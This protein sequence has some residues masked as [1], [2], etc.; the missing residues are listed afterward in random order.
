MGDLILSDNAR[1]PTLVDSPPI[2]QIKDLRTEFV[3]EQGVVKAVNGVSFEVAAGETLGIVG[4]SGSG[5]TVTMLSVMRLIDSPPGRIKDGQ[6][7]FKGRDLLALGRRE[8]RQVRG[9][10]IAM[11]FQDPL[12][13]L[14]PV[15]SIGDQL[16]EP[17]RLHLGMS[18][19]DAVERVKESLAQVGIPDPE[20]AL[21]A[22]P[23]QFSGGMRQRVM[24]AM[25]ISCNPTLLIADEPTTA[26]DVTVQEQLLALVN[27]L[28]SKLGMSVVWITHD[29]GVIAGLADRVL[30]M[31]AGE[32]VEQG[33][34]VTIFENPRHPYTQ[35]LLRSIPRLD[36]PRSEKLQ[37][38]PGTPPDQI[39]R[40]VGCQFAPRCAY[41]I[42]R[43]DEPPPLI[44]IDAEHASRCWVNPEIGGLA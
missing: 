24:V 10:E 25:A 2:L 20:R 17:I 28:Q 1:K 6:V 13:S 22:F 31:Y 42:D 4:E 30:V 5:K 43:C 23:H 39:H 19:K 14:N 16:L 32:I 41:R 37:P 15:Y 26:L 27:D 29:M 40:P 7:L 34:T 18:K 44:E 21:E 3:T 9:G 35:G 8:M 33:P 12:T 38:I 36:T 11:I